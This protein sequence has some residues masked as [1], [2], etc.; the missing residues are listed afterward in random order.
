MKTLTFLKTHFVNDF[1]LSEYKKMKACDNEN[2]KTLLFIDNHTNFLNTKLNGVQKLSFG[3]DSVDC[4]ILDEINYKET[5]LPYYTNDK[6]NKDFSSLMWYCCDYPL[7]IIRNQYPEYDYY[8][9]IESDVYMNNDSY[10]AFYEK[11]ENNNSDLIMALFK[12]I[13]GSDKIEDDWVYQ[14]QLKYSGIFPV[15]RI[16][17]KA[18]DFCYKRRL[19]L[20]KIF[21][22]ISDKKTYWWTYCEYFVPTECT[23]NGFECEPLTEEFIRIFPNYNL[24]KDILTESPNN[25]LYHPVKLNIKR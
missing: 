21:K 11:Y 14:G 20:A 9:Q 18:S 7:Y 10:T 12:S 23:L 24:E 17:N 6:F 5:G 2:H 4:F 22:K 15:V 8:W 25:K 16:S 19:E 3:D 1:I 13:N